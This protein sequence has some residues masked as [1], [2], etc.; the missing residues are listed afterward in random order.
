M[1]RLFP[2]CC[3]VGLIY[4]RSKSCTSNSEKPSVSTRNINRFQA[5]PLY[6][7]LN[8]WLPA[9]SVTAARYRGPICGWPGASHTSHNR[10]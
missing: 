6:G 1:A 2:L 4:K 3:V 8:V 5:D 9:G 7:F 10:T